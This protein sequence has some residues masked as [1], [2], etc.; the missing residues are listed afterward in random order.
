VPVDIVEC[1][2]CEESVSGVSSKTSPAG[3][4]KSKGILY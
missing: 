1:K 3:V 4:V 2:I